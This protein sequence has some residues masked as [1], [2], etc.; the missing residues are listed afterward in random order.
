[1]RFINLLIIL[2]IPFIS[3]SQDT[4]PDYSTAQLDSVIAGTK[5]ID[6][7]THFN[8][9]GDNQV[10]DID[11]TTLINRIKAI[12]PNTD[13][14]DS[15]SFVNDSLKID[16]W[17]KANN[18][19]ITT[20]YID[21]VINKNEVVTTLSNTLPAGHNI[22]TYTNES[23]VTTNIN[24]SVIGVV[25]NADGSTT[26][27][28][29]DG[30][31]VT[32]PTKNATNDLRK[33]TDGTIVRGSDDPANAKGS[34]FTSSIY[35]HMNGFDDVWVG[36]NGSDYPTILLKNNGDVW[37]GANNS[38]N[39]NN[40][41]LFLFDYAKNSF[42]IGGATPT[43]FINQI[44]NN[45]F[46][47]MNNNT[48]ILNTS[49]WSGAISC[50]NSIFDSG[51]LSTS[52]SAYLANTNGVTVSGVIYGSGSM[53]GVHS[54]F[55]AGSNTDVSISNST[56]SAILSCNNTN[57][58]NSTQSLVMGSDGVNVTNASN[59]FDMGGTATVF[60]DSKGVANIGGA[61]NTFINRTNPAQYNESSALSSRFC[62]FDD[63]Y[64]V[65]AISSSDCAFQNRYFSS[66]VSAKGGT[67]TADHSVVIAGI[68]AKGDSYSSLNFGHY[69]FSLTGQSKTTTGN[70]NDFMLTGANG[71][72]SSTQSYGL[73]LTRHSRFLI[74]S[75]GYS[76]T[77][78][79]S[80]ITPEVTA[81]FI[82][83]D[84][85]AIPAGTTAERP[86][87]PTNNTT[88]KSYIRY[89]TTTGK[90]E[91]FDLN[92]STWVNLN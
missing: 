34:Q 85:I 75:T 76:T 27:T 26:I 55:I 16:V 82:G 60:T 33:L 59:V 30:S 80:Q 29:E 57:M 13:T 68:G 8:S 92:T 73:T 17:D 36:A 45:T 91:G 1:M 67:I 90:F 50:N 88:L 32:I 44:G 66:Y 71:V 43:S 4:K 9:N 87:N 28:K 22:G 39:G 25:N 10:L 54:S 56:K 74:N 15:I 20:Y 5:K 65:T 49:Y 47:L 61:S 64:N 63:S 7:P 3:Y 46:S 19:L 48:N 72:N 52:I 40:A 2:L 86:A 89:N 14:R 31:T 23:N 11:V 42:I 12:L 6:I 77:L 38:I 41:H 62:T 35:N 21:D 37:M 24:E 78:T 69:G 18:T 84:A 58:I 79:Q 81:E 70:I 51:I 83:T 53:T